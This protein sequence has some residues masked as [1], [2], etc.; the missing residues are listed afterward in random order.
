MGET[1]LLIRWSFSHWY[2]HDWLVDTF[3]GTRE[4]INE[5]FELRIQDLRV[6]GSSETESRRSDVISMTMTFA[7]ASYHART[8][9]LWSTFDTIRLPKHHFQSMLL[10]E[11]YIHLIIPQ[12]SH[13]R[14]PAIHLVVTSYPFKLPALPP[15]AQPSRPNSAL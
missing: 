7:A 1:Q 6:T 12:H 11:I 14:Q 2:G 15:E 3:D 5:S 8:I 4:A 10:R 13:P 9:Q